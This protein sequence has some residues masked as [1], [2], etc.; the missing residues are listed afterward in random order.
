MIMVVNTRYIC[1]QFRSMMTMHRW[2]ETIILLLT[3]HMQQDG[4]FVSIHRNDKQQ[5][6][7]SDARQMWWNTAVI[8]NIT[9][10]IFNDHGLVW[11]TQL[12]YNMV[13]FYQ[14]YTKLKNITFWMHITSPYLA[15]AGASSCETWVSVTMGI[16]MHY[17][18]S[19]QG[20]LYIM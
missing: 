2:C 16:G 18:G 9:I 3:Q 12:C 20:C 10:G 6:F 8:H 11:T 5:K 15:F 13:Q 17:V 19:S 4:E 1:A 14:F 7:S